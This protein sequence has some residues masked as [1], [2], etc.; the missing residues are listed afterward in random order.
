MAA[1]YQW[2]VPCIICEDPVE[3]HCNTCGDALC[4]RCKDNHLK[5]NATKLHDIVPYSQRS[6]PVK[7]TNECEKHHG[8]T[9]NAWCKTCNEPVCTE[10]MLSAAHNRHNFG[11]LEEK[12]M[13]K[14]KEL[15][16]ELNFQS[17]L[18]VK[19]ESTLFSVKQNRDSY[20]K[21]IQVLSLGIG[22]HADKICKEVRTKEKK[23][24]QIL[25]DLGNDHQSKCIQ[26][27]SSI[28]KDI[29]RCKNQLKEIED[30]LRSNDSTK[31]LTLKPKRGEISTDLTQT[32]NTRPVF[33]P[34]DIS[35]NVLEKAFGSLSVMGIEGAKADSGPI[36]ST[37]SKSNASVA[38]S[39]L[40]TENDLDPAITCVD[41]NHAWVET[42]DATLKLIARDGSVMN[43]ILFDFSLRLMT[44][45]AEG[46]LL[47]CDFSNKCIRCLR[48]GSNVMSI[49]F[50]TETIPHDIC[51]LSS[52]EILVSSFAERRMTIYSRTGHV[53][54]EVDSKLFRYPFSVTQ[55]KDS[56]LLYVSDKRGRQLSA[57]GR[58]VCFGMNN[59]K[60][61]QYTGRKN[62]LDFTPC[63]LCIGRGYVIV[64]NF[65]SNSVHI[66]SKEL[67]F[68]QY[69]M[70]K[71]SVT[72]PVCIDVDGDGHAWV[73][74]SQTH[75][76]QIVKYRV[77]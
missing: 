43:T 8:Q 36:S 5:S 17:S 67:N 61:Y 19:H 62:A 60:M 57:P 44:L 16:R 31:I 4:S 49:L 59:K 6:I 34:G 66:L 30:V 50:R 35:V 48:K 9:F 39:T 12:I 74:E 72:R 37:A 64:S 53:V 22:A 55:H 29:K 27:E 14:R 42:S 73:G 18:L 65:E 7:N 20:E 21:E 10:C 68:L 33:K 75:A 1:L 41:A 11:K 24:M 56:K 46:D 32:L 28:K 25:Q 47:L 51:C 63:C 76:I 45:S 77:K 23:A 71:Q 26:Y 15:Q 54:K 13:E 69:L 3:F 40:L 52:G 38:I 70:P 58:V 2:T